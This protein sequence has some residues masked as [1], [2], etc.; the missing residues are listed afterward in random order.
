MTTNENTNKPVITACS[1]GFP[2]QELGVVMRGNASF[3]QSHQGGFIKGAN[4]NL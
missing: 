3:E 4:S 2:G 1:E